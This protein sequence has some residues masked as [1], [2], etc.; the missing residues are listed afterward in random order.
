MQK[1]TAAITAVGGYVPEYRLTNAILETMID[2][3]DEWI[4]TRTGVEE[5]RILKGDG[6]ATSD[7]CIPAV[8]ELCKK[9]GINPE[10]IDCMICATVTPDMI[11]PATANIICDKIGAV[12]AWGYDLSAACSGFLFALTNGAALIESGRYK[13]V[14]VIGAD[15]MSAIVDYTDRT[16]CILFGDGAGAVLLEPSTE[17]VGVADSL[18]KSDGGGKDYLHMKAGGS[19]R[20]ASVE[21]V[22]N[23][24]HYIYQSGPQVF[25]AAV[26]GMADAAYDLLLR[27]NLTGDDIA[28]LVPHQAN[29]RIIDATANRMGLSHDKVMLNIQRFGNT[30]AATIPLCL[31]E[32]EK[33]L[34][35]GD[36]LVLAAFGGG[37]TWGAT[38]VTWAY[39]S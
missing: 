30:T 6:L 36:K 28:W 38:L 39:N 12:N 34:K 13:K 2:T 32:W 16:T 26:K 1:I 35:K 5:R 29:K 21:T 3:N 9:R 27:N 15:K 19:L 31:W 18:L 17:N 4:K 25:K 23:K 10:E 20:P 24:E 22:Q 14:V 33:Q 7:M 37:F 11:F 8:L